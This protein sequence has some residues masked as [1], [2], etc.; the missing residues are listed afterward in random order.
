MS[1]PAKAVAMFR[2]PLSLQPLASFIYSLSPFAAQL[3]GDSLKMLHR[4][5][6]PAFSRRSLSGHFVP[7]T[8]LPRNILKKHVIASR[9]RS[10]PHIC[11]NFPIGIDPSFLI[12]I[13]TNSLVKILFSARNSSFL[14]LFLKIYLEFGTLHSFSM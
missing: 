9:R 2:V 1:G 4:S 12:K 10:N 3:L 13:P 7:C 14:I 11:C 6:L 8:A 5:I